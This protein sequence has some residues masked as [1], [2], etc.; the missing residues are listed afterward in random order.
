[1]LPDP[2]VLLA[3]LTAVVQRLATVN[4]SQSPTPRGPMNGTGSMHSYDWAAASP[5]AFAQNGSYVGGGGVSAVCYFFGRDLYV[6]LG[7]SVPIG[8]ISAA[9]GGVKIATMA[10]ADALSDDTCGGTRADAPVAPP[11]SKEPFPGASELWNAMVNPLLQMRLSG[12]VVYQGE[13]NDNWPEAYV[14]CLRILAV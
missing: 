2:D 3:T 7:E 9:I 6:E 12:V 1:M 11:P 8:I 4:N 10:S 13:S 5:A 14:D